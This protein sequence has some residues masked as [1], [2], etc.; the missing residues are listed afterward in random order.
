ML[1]LLT[2]ATLAPTEL[3]PKF[4]HVRMF[5]HHSEPTIPF[6]FLLASCLLCLPPL[7]PV[8]RS[9]FSHIW[10]IPGCLHPGHILQPLSAPTSVHASC[11][12]HLAIHHLPFWFIRWPIPSPDLLFV[13]PFLMQLINCPLHYH[14]LHTNTLTK[15]CRYPHE[16]KGSSNKSLPMKPKAGLHRIVWLKPECRKRPRE[17]EI[18]QHKITSSPQRTVK[19]RW[20]HFR[21]PDPLQYKGEWPR[22]PPTMYSRENIFFVQRIPDH[23][24]CHRTSPQLH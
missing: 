22:I 1:P 19:Y 3:S 14:H 7:C 17:T 11:W 18:P 5:F 2:F 8:M 13:C 6:C 20:L 24:I 23:P 16:S 15:G 12:E 4:V 10:S 9:T 21:L